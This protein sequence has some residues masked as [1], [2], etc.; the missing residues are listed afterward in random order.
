M[1]FTKSILAPI[2]SGDGV[3]ISIMSRHTQP[4]GVT[5]DTRITAN[6]YQLHWPEVA[7]PPTLIGDYYRRGISWEEFSSR[8]ELFLA[9]TA[10]A[11][12]KI[13]ELLLMAHY[14]AVTVMCIE[15]TPTWCHRRLLAE[16]CR[17]RDPRITLEIR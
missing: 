6:R 16:L 10:S 9:I 15:D 3:R 13:E 1:L 5:P 8:Y 2:E 14:R 7:P 4:D 11:R 17:K 12:E